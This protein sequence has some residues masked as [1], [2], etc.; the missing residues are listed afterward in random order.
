MPFNNDLTNILIGA[1]WAC[2]NVRSHINP[3]FSVVLDSVD[4]IT[5]LFGIAQITF[6]PGLLDIIQAESTPSL[7]WF[8]SLPSVIPKKSW[9]VYVLILKMPGFDDLLYIGSGTNQ[10]RGLSVRLRDHVVG[11]NVP[12]NV[13]RAKDFGYTITDMRTLAHCNIPAPR[14]IPRLRTVIVALEAL[15]A[16]IFWAYVPGKSTFGLDHLCPWNREH[17]A[18]LGLCSHSPLS[19][20]ITRRP[21]EIDFTDDELEE[22]ARIRKAKEAAYQHDYQRALRANPTPAYK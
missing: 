1:L 22:M 14:Y 21:G 6:C 7:R 11:R 8:E 2:V 17:F 18:W 19:E 15:F 13:Q 3:R 10:D 9:G 4:T 20:S 12:R 16:A 5:E